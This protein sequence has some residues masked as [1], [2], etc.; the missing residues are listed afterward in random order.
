VQPTLQ[1]SD[2]ALH[3]LH[4]HVLA[5]IADNRAEGVDEWWAEIHEKIPGGKGGGG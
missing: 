2:A 1:M 3:T 5:R 4:S